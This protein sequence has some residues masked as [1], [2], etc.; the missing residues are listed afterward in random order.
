MP[1]DE[2]AD[3]GAPADLAITLTFAADAGQQML[4]SSP[5]VSEV[6]GRL[7]SFV[8]AVGLPECQVDAT[9]SSLT[10]SYWK[11]GLSTPLT[12]MRAV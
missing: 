11:P 8:A 12:V 2:H 5:S 7:R 9:L 6:I 3:S 1:A 4:E 10:L